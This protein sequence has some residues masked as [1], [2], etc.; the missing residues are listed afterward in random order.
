MVT[1]R[2]SACSRKE[3]RL[4]EMLLKELK[5]IIVLIS[6]IVAVYLVSR[7]VVQLPERWSTTKRL[8]ATS[9]SLPHPSANLFPCHTSTPQGRPR[10]PTPPWP[11]TPTPAPPPPYDNDQRDLFNLLDAEPMAQF[12]TEQQRRLLSLLLLSTFNA[13]DSIQQIGETIRDVIQQ[14][15]VTQRNRHRLSQ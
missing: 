12:T 3:S 13:N 6:L 14:T 9:R 1:S 10:E 5:Y 8:W 7:E 4:P 15:Y 11:R 2:I